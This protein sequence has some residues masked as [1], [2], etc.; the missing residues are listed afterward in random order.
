MTRTMWVL[1]AG[2]LVLLATPRYAAAKKYNEFELKEM[3]QAREQRK[4][5]KAARQEEQADDQEEAERHAHAVRAHHS[6]E[7]DPTYDP[8]VDSNSE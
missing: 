1:L 7:D 5:E 4:E 6:K 8:D 2:A 3:H